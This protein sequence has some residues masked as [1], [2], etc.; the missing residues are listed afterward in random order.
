MNKEEILK[1]AKEKYPIGTIFKSAYNPEIY[2]KC[3]I[4][5][6]SFIF[7]NDNLFTCP[8]DH[9]IFYAEFNLKGIQNSWAE[10]IPTPIKNHELW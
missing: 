1:L 5:S 2:S 7:E 9:A 6:D 3:E 4:K 10:I 8:G